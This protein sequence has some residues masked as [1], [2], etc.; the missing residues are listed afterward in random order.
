[1]GRVVLGLAWALTQVHSVGGLAGNGKAGAWPWGRL[2]AG[3][4][5]APLTDR[6]SSMQRWLDFKRMRTKLQGLLSPRLHNLPGI[7]FT[8][9]GQSEQVTRPA[10]IQGE[11]NRLHLCVGVALSQYQRLGTLGGILVAIF[12]NNLPKRYKCKSVAEPPPTSHTP[13]W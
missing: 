7:T 11:R 4:H 1:M 2:C 13:V 10:Q 6:S 3:E 5:W 8:V 12:A 9:F